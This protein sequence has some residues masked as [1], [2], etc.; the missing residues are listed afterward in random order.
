MRDLD[1][2]VQ[3]LSGDW[4]VTDG[5]SVAIS[6]SIKP[7]GRDALAS[8]SIRS[9]CSADGRFVGSRSR[10]CFTNSCHSSPVSV[11]VLAGK[12]ETRGRNTDLEDRGEFTG[13]LWRFGAQNG[14]EDLEGLLPI[15]RSLSVRQFN[16]LH[17]S[18]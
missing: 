11:R 2:R 15:K 3:L 14:L 5:A 4:R 8:Q 9:N 18:V 17:Q 16:R 6:A 12:A 13:Q 1:E 10:H 7:T